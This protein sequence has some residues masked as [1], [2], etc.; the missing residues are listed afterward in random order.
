MNDK[1]PEIKLSEQSVTRDHTTSR[2]RPDQPVE[3][4]G[5]VGGVAAG[6]PVF[7]HLDTVATIL[8]ALPSDKPVEAGGL[9]VGCN[10]ADTQGKYLL[11]TDA[12]P[13]TLAEGQR[14]CLTFTHQ[15]WDQMLT[16]KHC[17]FPDELIVGWYHTHPGLG[18][19]LS[20]PDLFIHQHFFSDPMQVALVIDPPDFTW[21]MFC[22]QEGG[23]AAATGYYIYGQINDTYQ[24]LEQ[25]LTK[26]GV[27][28]PLQAE[29]I[30]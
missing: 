21:G 13:A 26:Y 27:S 15:A 28:W 18:V 16:H 8:S 2:P 3:V 22:W 10:C 7:V 19:F 23:L 17:E 30:T 9:L 6:L 4:V 12:I 24:A 5:K 20:G 29:G 11:I 1:D 14:L 25:I